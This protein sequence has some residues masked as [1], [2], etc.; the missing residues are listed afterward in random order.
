MTDDPRYII[1][2][3]QVGSYMKV[4]AI[5]PETMLE[6]SIVGPANASEET[7][8]RTAVRKL[9]YMLDKRLSGPAS[10]PGMVV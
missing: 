3:H 9:E 2:F 4:S 6:V 10:R 5:D 7:L 8:R 1:E